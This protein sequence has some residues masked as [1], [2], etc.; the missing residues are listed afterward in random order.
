MTTAERVQELLAAAKL[1]EELT[2]DPDEF[3][4]PRQLRAKASNIV[5]TR[6]AIVTQAIEAGCS[7]RNAKALAEWLF[8]TYTLTVKDLPC[9][10]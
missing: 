5:D 10:F 1:I 8:E 4:S 7:T 2:G 3:I 9:P 6:E